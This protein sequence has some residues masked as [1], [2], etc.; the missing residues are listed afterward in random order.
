MS[1]FSLAW[2]NLVRQK[3]RTVLMGAVVAFGFAA[4]ALAGGFI[5]Q[6]FDGLKEGTIRTVGQLQAVDRRAVTRTEEKTLEFGLRGASRARAIASGD[7]AVSA[8]L[9]RIDFVGLATSGAKSVPYLGIGV[10]PEP[11]AAAT[12]A[13]ELVVAGKYLSG[14]G[15]DGV[16][17]GTGLASAL[18]VKPGDSVTLMATTPDGSLNAVDAVVTGLADVQIKEL[19]DRYLACGIALA[20][21]LLQSPETVTKLVVFL[22]PRADEGKTAERLR[23][24]LNAAGYPVAIRNWRELAV[25]YGQVKLLYIGI[26]GFVGAVLVVIV[27]LSAAIVMTMAVTERT[28]EIGTLRALGTRPS[29]ILKMFLMEGTALAIA[30]CAAGMIL[31]LL[32]RAVLNASGIILPPP[33]GATHGMPIHVQFYPLAYAAGLS[34]MIVTML[35]ASYFPAKRASRLSIVEALAHI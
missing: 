31:A 25:F 12:F 6:S 14:D 22:K 23:L 32:V 17:L 1:A 5:A 15:G 16:V 4:F 13:R 21:R 24:A 27:I 33:P 7:P 29:G 26:F 9:P 11:E 34:A 20:S 10:D 2:R 8:V 3:R 18:Q 19:N 30:G 28:R 35:V